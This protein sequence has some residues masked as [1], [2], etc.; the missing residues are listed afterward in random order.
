MIN[1]RG[2]FESVKAGRDLGE[3]ALPRRAGSGRGA[4]PWRGG[5]GFTLVE[6]ALATVMVGGLMVVAMNLVGASRL[7]QT[8]YADRELASVLAQDLLLE[9]LE[10]PYTDEEGAGGIGL[11]VGELLTLRLTLDDSDDYDGYTES[12]P[13]DPRGEAIPG[14]E[15]LTRSVAVDFVL[16]GDPS[17]VTASDTGVKRVVVTVSVGEQEL[18][19]VVGYRTAAWPGPGQMRG[20]T[21]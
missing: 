9:V 8:R 12:P 11:S 1:P 16:P 13:T 5:R 15:R 20:A 10:Q 6:T 7:S 14:A 18:A 4:A 21:P 19:S 3:R 2:V 17:K